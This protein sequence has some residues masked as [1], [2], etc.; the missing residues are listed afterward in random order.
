MQQCDNDLDRILSSLNKQ[1]RL[2][3]EFDPT[4]VLQIIA[5]PGTGKT[6]VLTSRVAF[7]LL[8]HKWSPKDIVVTTFTNKAA[9][10]MVERLTS[11]LAHTGVNVG[12]LN[13]GTFHSVCLRI[14][15]RF[16]DKIG[17]TPGWRI[18]EEKEVDAIVNEM[19]EKTPDQ[20]RDYA[21]SFD[22][23]V[24]LC[25]PKGNGEEWVIH[26]KMIKK[27]I[28]RLKSC[29][30]LPEEYANESVHDSALAHYY[31][32]YHKE[33]TKLNALDF[34]D[35]LMYCFRLLSEERCMPHIKHVFVD[36]FQD[37]NSI[38]M[39]LMFML[40][41]GNHHVSRGITVV[42]D[43]DQSI[44]A[45]RN[46]LVHNFQEMANKSPLQCSQIVLIENYRSSQKILNTSETL[47]KQQTKGRTLR[48]PLHAQFDC[49]FPPVYVNF[50]VQFLQ[51]TSLAKEILYLKALPSLFSYSDFAILVRQRRQIKSIES[52]LI[53]HRIPYHIIRGR[54]FWD[55]K[56]ITA[57]LNLLR[58]VYSDN[59]KNALLTSL[60]YPSRGLGQ[61]SAD[62]LTL[63]MDQNPLESPYNVLK[64]VASN[65]LPFSGG[66]K[67]KSVIISFVHMIDSCRSLLGQPP[68]TVLEGIFDQLYQMSGLQQEY[69]YVDGKNKSSDTGSE[70][71]ITAKAPNYENPRHKN[72]MLLKSYF[73]ENKAIED[74]LI[75]Q[76]NETSN[77]VSNSGSD[78]KE[79]D[80]KTYICN[81]F[82]SLSVFTTELSE[83]DTLADDDKNKNGEGQIT[84]STIHGAKGLEWP[85]V[86]IPGCVEGIIPSIFSKDDEDEDIDE[87]DED[88]DA[89]QSNENKTSKNN[90][91]SKRGKNTEATLDEERR[92]FFVAQTRA[93]VL[94][95]LSSVTE[96]N[97]ATVGGPSRFL[98]PELMSTM[99]D[100]QKVF[101]NEQN[102]KALYK[103]LGK[104]MPSLEPS[105][106]IKQLVR[107]YSKFIQN[108]R[109]FVWNGDGVRKSA[110]PGFTEQHQAPMAAL[111]AEFT[112]AAAQLKVESPEKNPVK[113]YSA[114]SSSK[115]SSVKGKDFSSS[116]KSYAPTSI[117]KVAHRPSIKAPDNYGKVATKRKLFVSPTNSPAKTENN[118]KKSCLNHIPDS[119]LSP[120][121]TTPRV[122][123]EQ[124][125]THSNYF[126]QGSQTTRRPSSRKINTQPIKIGTHASITEHEPIYEVKPEPS[127]WEDTTAAEILHN[128]DD[129]TVDNRPIF[130]TAK[131]LAKAVKK[132][133]R[134]K[135]K[136]NLERISQ[137]LVTK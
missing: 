79:L 56:E 117:R 130:A 108:S 42:G 133:T 44:Y 90:T 111:N 6:K 131:T 23:I 101:Q 115:R 82:N 92:M 134:T 100:D 94:L 88:N 13:I 31:E 59:E 63:L 127:R 53:E 72:V 104:G 58:C 36:E 114:M 110:T 93:K 2:A 75:D 48:T 98:T 11:M 85:V 38:Q 124:A 16:G 86:L 132:P 73:M 43:P 3:T 87:D 64:N 57:I 119:N 33:L 80:A 78:G 112:T 29:A 61:T 128:P 22:R 109:I 84:I 19:I 17:L 107:D 12:D 10:E 26:P 39:D 135:V 91:N 9:K 21:S 51:G 25:R 71:D 27:E 52:A 97:N 37:T 67:I 34:D 137:I 28:S 77:G 50:P 129:L 14:L 118:T 5:G 62:K 47:I 83:T 74:L 65:Q 102:I 89:E 20:V 68:S 106:S 99:V 103:A 32:V 70:R 35:L 40:A 46:A 95:Y 120:Q 15:T 7:L 1:Q 76:K 45:F 81:F 122:N 55:L 113:M 8:K 66:N 49:K 116:A 96:S 69:L 136:K 60:L 30:I 121:I 105:F 24:N 18:I 54:A 126:N 4:Q 41:K 123:L 125:D